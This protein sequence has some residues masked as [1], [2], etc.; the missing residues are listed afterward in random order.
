MPLCLKM[1]SRISRTIN[2]AP[3]SL[4]P[5][6]CCF[7]TSLMEKENRLCSPSILLVNNHSWLSFLLS[8]LNSGCSPLLLISATSF[9]FSENILA[10]HCVG[11]FFMVNSEVKSYNRIRA[12]RNLCIHFTSI[13][14][15]LALYIHAHSQIELMSDAC[16]SYHA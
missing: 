12:T 2:R 6:S 16:C 4:C 1:L 10:S 8:N 11:P 3:F 14:L 13:A 5:C 9:P 7:S 15:K